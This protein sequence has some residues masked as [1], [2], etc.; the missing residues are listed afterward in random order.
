MVAPLQTEPV[1]I[2]LGDVMARGVFFQF[3]EIQGTS[4]RWAKKAVDVRVKRYFFGVTIRYP[5][6]MYTRYKYGVSDIIL[7]EMQLVHRL[8]AEA[9]PYLLQNRAFGRTLQGESVLCADTVLDYDGKRSQTLKKVGRISNAS[10]WWHV[11]TVREVLERHGV[12]LFGVFH[13][14][15]HILVQK[16]S[17]D[18]WRPVLVDIV[19]SGR[20]MYPFQFHLWRAASVQNKYH[21]QIERFRNRFMPISQPSS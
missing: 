3:F 6:R 1:P 10:F 18:E 11:D 8:P 21:R 5:M 15:N 2:V 13:G 7:Y 14:G 4:A 17:P 9:Q 19:K 16:R 12:L 20:T